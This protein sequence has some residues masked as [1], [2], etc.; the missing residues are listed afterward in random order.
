MH[1]IKYNIIPFNGTKEQP[2][3]IAHELNIKFYK[4]TTRKVLHNNGVVNFNGTIL[5]DDTNRKVLHNNNDGGVVNFTGIIQ[6]FY[7]ETNETVS[8][9]SFKNGFLH[10]YDGNPAEITP[11]V[12]KWYFD[13][14]LHREDGPAIV[15]N[16]N[17]EMFKSSYIYFLH[18]ID[19]SIGEYLKRIP[20]ENAILL[21]LQC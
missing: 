2:F 16:S 5:Y 18:G 19:Y 6:A 8:I 4:D 13:G 20:E 7:K 17:N 9:Y 15:H 11:Y 1:T 12:K 14:N 3:D 10:S 21:S